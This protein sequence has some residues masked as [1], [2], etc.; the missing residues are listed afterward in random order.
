MSFPFTQIDELFSKHDSTKA[1][2][3]AVAIVKDGEI[4]Y[5][6]GFGMATL[7][8]SATIQPHTAFYI[9]SCSKQFAAF[10]IALLEEKGLL[11]V[12]DDVRKY[13]P[14]IPDYGHVIQIQHLIRHTSGL[15]DYLE[16]NAL[17]G[18]ANDEL[19]T[20]DDA[21]N[22]II[23]QRNLNFEPGSRYLYSNSGYFLLSELVLR[24][25]GQTLRQFAQEN[26]FGPLGMKN[27]HFHDNRHEPVPNRAIGYRFVPGKGFLINIPGLETVGSGGIYST[28]EDLALWDR[29]FYHNILGKGRQ[30][31]MQR[32]LETTTF[33]NG[34]PF[35]YAF[36]LSVEK[37][38]GI[39]RVEHSGNNGGYSAEFARF[40]EHHLTIICLANGNNIS[41]PNIAAQAADILLK[42]HFIDT[43]ETAEEKVTPVELKPG[44]L[45]GKE[46][47]YFSEEGEVSFQVK[48]ADRT[49]LMCIAGHELP[50]TPSSPNRFHLLNMPI[51]GILD[52]SQENGKPIIYLDFERGKTPEKLVKMPLVASSPVEKQ[53]LVGDYYSDE[54]SVMARITMDG[55]NLCLKLGRHKGTL[56]T[57]EN[58]VFILENEDL[59]NC[60]LAAQSANG[61]VQEFSLNAGRVQNIMFVRR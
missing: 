46:G 28:V 48:I 55:E 56:I 7:E 27:T 16:L 4:V 3:C 37:Y 18:R 43:Q 54:L 12:T 2:G 23:S 19:I 35:T 20:P 39:D 15:R 25:T 58:Q 57:C 11:S 36:G 29:N 32:I 59:G 14:E 61:H 22:A 45:A 5:K 47:F 60:I 8:H 1:P 17:S 40:P 10:C 21:L 13:I 31:L 34:E 30:E 44:D 6:K 42:D 33:S 38:R 49:L 24:I 50:L 52:F 51:R 41:A 26:I 53:A 9:A